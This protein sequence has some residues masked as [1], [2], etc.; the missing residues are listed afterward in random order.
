MAQ[1]VSKNE[2]TKNRGGV[3]DTRDAVQR[4]WQC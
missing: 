1:G 4:G 2:K 3:L